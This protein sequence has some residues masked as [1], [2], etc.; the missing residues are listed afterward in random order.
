MSS[1]GILGGKPCVRG[2]RLSVAFILELLASGA[3]RDEILAAYP[4]IT[5][6][7]LSAALDYAARS[8]RNEVVWD[9]RVPA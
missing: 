7:G 1:P 3:S 2:T 8:L 4:Q 6:E 5:A 9:V